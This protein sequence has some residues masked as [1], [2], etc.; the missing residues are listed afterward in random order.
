MR[1]AIIFAD[2]PLSCESCSM[3][4]EEQERCFVSDNV[5]VNRTDRYCPIIPIK[6][7]DKHEANY[8]HGYSDGYDECLSDF[9]Q[10]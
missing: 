10:I 8:I 6:C 5:S 7:D 4:N 2:I 1:G 3:Y 9:S